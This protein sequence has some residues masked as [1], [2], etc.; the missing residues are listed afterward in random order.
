MS[1][2]G[3]PLRVSRSNGHKEGNGRRAED[4]R[5]KKGERR[6]RKEERGRRLGDASEDWGC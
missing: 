5:E 6:K 1:L 2:V 4:R 3:L